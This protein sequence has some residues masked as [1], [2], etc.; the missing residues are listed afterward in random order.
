[1]S[2]IKKALFFV[3]A[4]FCLN[5]AAP[6]IPDLNSVLVLDDFNDAYGDAANQNSLG[7]IK[8]WAQYGHTFTGDYGYWYVYTTSVG[9]TPY[10]WVIAGV[11]THDTIN[12]DNTK[13][14]IDGQTLHFSFKAKPDTSKTGDARYPSAEVSCNFFGANDS[15]DLSKM[16]SISFKAKGSGTIRVSIMSRNIKSSG[17]WGYC[18]DTLSLK[19]AWTN[20]SIPIAKLTP[21]Q[22]S[23]SAGKVTWAQSKTSACGFQIKTQDSKN[24]EVNMD[25]IV[26]DGMKYSDVMA[27]VGVKQTFFVPKS[28]S[29]TATTVNNCPVSLFNS[30]GRI[31]KTAYTGTRS[32]ALPQ[33]T[34]GA[35]FVRMNNGANS[36]KVTVVK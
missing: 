36:H 32:V 11:S 26:F 20:V 23:A 10:S 33:T 18:G 19:S 35:Y 4:L 5:Y 22:Y 25:S 12:K 16:T 2:T 14:L 28:Y 30:S 31:I 17:D 29:N 9:T 13:L 1:M 6:V 7:A 8:G 21:D 3:G 15:I 24:A 27:K 34:P